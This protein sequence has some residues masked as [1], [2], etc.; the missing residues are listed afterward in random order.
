MEVW[1]LLY[2]FINFL[3]ER[4]LIFTPNALSL[5]IV[6]TVNII[7]TKQLSFLSIYWKNLLKLEIKLLKIPCSNRNCGIYSL[8]PSNKRKTITT[9]KNMIWGSMYNSARYIEKS[10]V[11]RWKNIR[12]VALFIPLVGFQFW[13]D[14]NCQ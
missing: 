9:N 14:L 12:C 1:L 7:V 4:I 2:Q 6:K 3:I 10:M 13:I 5:K 8:F 11:L